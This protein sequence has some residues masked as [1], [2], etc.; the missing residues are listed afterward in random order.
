MASQSTHSPGGE[1]RG[2]RLAMA[3][4]LAGV[5]DGYHRRP[6]RSFSGV[7]AL[8]YAS[9]RLEG[10][11]LREAGSSLSSMLERERIIRRQTDTS[12]EHDA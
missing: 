3:P 10:G 4:W 2:P 5:L 12:E 9:G 11:A 6:L 1:P 8:A 7:D